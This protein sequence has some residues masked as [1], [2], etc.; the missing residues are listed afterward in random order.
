MN[1]F[2]PERGPKETQ[3]EYKSRRALAKAMVQRMSLRGPHWPGINGTTSRQ[4]LRD[5]MRKSGAM[6]KRTRYAD[7]LM[8]SWAAKRREAMQG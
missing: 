4:Q 3:A 8:A 1:T 5:S 6:A 7:T 2:T